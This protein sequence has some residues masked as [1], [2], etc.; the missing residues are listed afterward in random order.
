LGNR[1]QREPGV[2]RRVL[3]V[4]WLSAVQV[5]ILSA[6]SRRADDLAGAVYLTNYSFIGF[7]GLQDIPLIGLA[8]PTLV[9]EV[10][11]ALWLTIVG[12]NE[13]KWRAHVHARQAGSSLTGARA[14]Q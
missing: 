13:T 6:D 7:L 9:A 3:R 8:R 14:T 4:D 5:Q 2:L 10:A 1:F 11:L 12:V